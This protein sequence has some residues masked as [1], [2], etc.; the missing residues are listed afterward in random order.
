[1]THELIGKVIIVTGAGR[2][3][4]RA[5]A[6]AVAEA[7]AAVVVTDIDPTTTAD[8]VSLIE[9]AGGRAVAAVGAVDDAR[10]GEALADLAIATFGR[11]DGIVAN[12]GVM[13][14]MPALEETESDLEFHFRVNVMGVALTVVPAMRAMAAAGGG[15]VVLVTSG[16]RAGMPGI[17]AYG[18]SKGAVASFA[19]NWAIDMAGTGVRV[20][21][22]SPVAHTD[23]FALAV[24][25]LAP[26]PE[27]ELIAPVVTYLL[28]DRSERITGQIVR[29]TGTTLGLYPSPVTL[30]GQIDRASW[31]A[32]EI[33]DAI[34]GELAGAI[35]DLSTGPDLV[36]VPLDE[37]ARA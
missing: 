9:A 16:A 27:P 23:M 26:P 10:F 20:N 4:G 3:L 34:D 28:S 11:L 12:A 15:S 24:S 32:A 17:G 8:T 14:A 36:R 13:R 21:A 1:M 18:A 5:Y 19:W 35:A 33:A 22:I 2:G 30:A 6:R 7:G 29:F 37:P 25:A 31:T